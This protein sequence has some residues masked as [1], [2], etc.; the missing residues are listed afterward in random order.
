MNKSRRRKP[1]QQSLAVDE[2]SGGDLLST[3]PFEGDLEAE[4][5]ARPPR[6]KPG[7]T[8]Y[9]GAA[10]LAV[11]GFAG[12]IQADRTWGGGSGSQ[13][14]GAAAQNPF[15][16]A[17]PG[18]AQ[19]GG[20][21]SGPGGT[22]NTGSPGN[23]TMGTV[24]RI[25]GKTIYLKTADGTTVKVAIDGSTKV[26]VS[27]NGTAKDLKSGTSVVVQGSADKSGTVTATTV[28]EAGAPGSA[29]GSPGG[30]FPNRGGT[31]PAG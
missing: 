26:K 15:G 1:S 31:G 16:G 4:L 18:G 10:I 27:K 14:K 30:G 22:G 13:A 28:N 25:D 12:G 19:F 20:L 8:L 9:L 21:G 24:Q 7:P 11:V 29:G 17:R 6:M 3:S 2:P 5:A 23:M